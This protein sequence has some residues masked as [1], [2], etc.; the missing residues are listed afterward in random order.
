MFDKPKLPENIVTPKK[1]MKRYYG[2]QNGK[3]KSLDIEKAPIY[4]QSTIELKRS[5]GPVKSDSEEE[6]DPKKV[7]IKRCSSISNMYKGEAE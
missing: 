5:P 4:R 3:A 6:F 2:Y 1:I 7:N